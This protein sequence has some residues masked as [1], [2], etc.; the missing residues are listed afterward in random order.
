MHLGEI[1]YRSWQA[2]NQEGRH[3][4]GSQRIKDQPM[5][6]VEAFSSVVSEIYASSID[7]ANWPVALTEIS[8]ALDATGASI[9]QGTG[10]SRGVLAAGVPVEAYGAYVDYYRPMDYVMEAV[11]TGPAGL[12]RGGQ[13]LIAL[14][15]RSEF[16]AGFLRPYEMDDGLFARLNVGAPPT[17]FLVAAPRRPEPFPT[18]ERV[19]L[20]SGI[21]P[22]LQ[23]ALLTQRRFAAV[24]ERSA[25]IC[26]AFELMRHG[27]IIVG[28]K[29]Q[30]IT[31][32]SSA[33]EILR[34]DDG[35]HIQSGRIGSANARVAHELRRACRIALVGGGSGVRGGHWLRCERPS[36]KRPFVIHV[37]PLHRAGD[38]NEVRDPSA[39]ITIRDP[40]R[41]T[42]PPATLLRRLY[43]LTT[44][45]AE[46]TIRLA[47]G[48]NLRD[49]AADLAVS[50]QTV[51]TH[52]QHIFDKTDTHRQAELV[53]LLLTLSP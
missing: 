1:S 6:T 20:L 9:L 31:L 29:G 5:V 48:D 35:L 39:L 17:S 42:E 30:V 32:N 10:P 14:K 43:G 3:T 33:E 21:L 27:V 22:H 24:V 49:I 51:R 16:E 38:G 52:L 4:H 45:E 41:E 37:T 8:R 26:G 36:G 2:S 44:G 25:D 40:E 18:A 47:R 46:V 34:S 13:E 53:R 23:Q 28:S 7:P 50:Y 15:T 12:I 11:E 19:K